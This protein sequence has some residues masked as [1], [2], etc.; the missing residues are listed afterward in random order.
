MP[1]ANASPC[2]NGTGLS[3]NFQIR[4][5][6]CSRPWTMDLCHEGSPS[7][8]AFQSGTGILLT[9]S[10]LPKFA[11][12]KT[13]S[14]D[15][16]NDPQILLEVPENWPTPSDANC[17]S[18]IFQASLMA[19]LSDYTAGPSPWRAMKTRSVEDPKIAWFPG[20]RNPADRPTASSNWQ[21]TCQKSYYRGGTSKRVP[22]IAS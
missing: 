19:T 12:W 22:S 18:T 5:L 8:G 4:V 17:S 16:V 11:G 14:V 10:I 13:K 21:V 3:C 20:K 6:S 7:R 15:A 9:L 1:R 2:P